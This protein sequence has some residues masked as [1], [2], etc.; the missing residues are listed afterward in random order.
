MDLKSSN[1]SEAVKTEKRRD[2]ANKFVQ[3][4]APCNYSSNS[5]QY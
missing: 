3:Q 4:S 5:K 2:L 1:L